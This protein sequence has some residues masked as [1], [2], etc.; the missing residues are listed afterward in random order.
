[1][2]PMLSEMPDT[3]PRVGSIASKKLLAASARREAAKALL[4]EAKELL[5]RAKHDRYYLSPTE[6]CLAKMS[7]ELR[8]TLPLG[9]RKVLVRKKRKKATPCRKCARRKLV[10][11]LRKKCKQPGARRG[12]VPVRGRPCSDYTALLRAI[13][14]LERHS[15]RFRTVRDKYWI[16]YVKAAP[17][18]PCGR[19]IGPRRALQRST[20]CDKACAQTQRKKQRRRTSHK[21]KQEALNLAIALGATL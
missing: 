4:V 5:E 16:A 9:P 19:V 3:P 10:D 2:K 7:R 1:M 6:L 11:S 12:G 13:T 20:T 8:R 14:E 15:L 18:C 21:E 17:V